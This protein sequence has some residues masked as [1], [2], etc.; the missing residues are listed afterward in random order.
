M[1]DPDAPSSTGDSPTRPNGPRPNVLACPSPTTARFILLVVATLAT[2]LFVG[3]F[4]HN[5]VLGDRWQREVVACASGLPYAEAEGA[6]VLTTWQA[7]AECTAD[8]E[9]R[10]AIFAFA[11]L[12]VAAV[13][14]FVI[15]KRSPRRLERRRRLR[16]AD[17]RFAAARQRFTELSHAAGLT[18]PPT[19]MIGPATQR[20]AFSYGLPGSQRVVMPV[21]ALIRPQCPEFTAL[22][23]HE[24]AHV[25]RRDVTVA[26]AAK[27]IGYAVAPLLLVPALL[28]VLTGELSLLTDYVW[29]AV[30]LGAVVTLT[31]AAILRSREHDADLLAAR[32]GSSVPELSAVLAQ[33]PDMR[34]RHL[35]HLIANH[36]YAH[37]RIAVLDNPAS[38][39]RASFVDAAAAAF[40]AGLMP[41]LIDLVV[42]P[43]LTGTAG[44]GVTDLVAAAVMGPLV[45]ATIGLASWRACLVSRVSGAAVH[46]G[47]VA[48]GVLVGFLLGEAASLA[49]Y[50]PGGYHPHP[51]PLLLSVTALSA[52][53]ATVATVGLGELWA[54]AAGRLPSARSFWLTAVLV[55]G[56]LF[57]A[58]LWAAMKVQK[59]LEWGGWGMASLTLTDYFARPTMVVGTLVL[60]LAAAWPIWLARRD[61]VTPAWLLESGTGRSWPATDRP[62]ARFTVIAG[63]LAGTCGAAVIAVFR[64]LA[65]AAADDAQAAQRLYSYVFLAGAVAAAAT[66]TVECFWPGRGAGA[67]LISAPVAAVTAMAGLVVINTL[68]GGTLTWTFA[69]D[70]G[71][72]PIGLALLSQTFALSIVAF[73]PRGRRTSRRIGLAAIVVVATL[74][75]L[76]ASAVITARDVL[77]PI[78][79]KSIASGEPRPLDEDVACGSCR[80]IGPV[81]GHANRQYW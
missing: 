13:A 56:L 1:S 72:Q 73:L 70:I 69:Y 71:R 10:R 49:Q 66:I 28:A 62:A 50:G 64:A 8:A 53:G 52:V 35:R 74:A 63:L 38:I 40:L 12:A 15:F 81:T 21:A 4:V 31:R 54:D 47:P 23:A 45:G 75:I 16:P 48:A 58:T 37:R 27:S 41:Y 76:A 43:L 24:L 61:T 26:W 39:A 51:S 46:R 60:A 9:H 17:E 36:P 2:G 11:G 80:V 44:V 6:D 22:A 59:S 55:P 20:D 33:M 32:M 79:A 68:L 25:A 5:M 57:T 42:V 34:S 30:L 67:A 14:A 18:R 29:R 7:W 19:L 65:G 78:A 3:V 77:V